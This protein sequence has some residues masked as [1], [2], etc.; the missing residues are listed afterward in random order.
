MIGRDAAPSRAF[1]KLKPVLEE[2]GLEVDLMVGDGQLL[3]QSD[4]EVVLAVE[5]ANLMLLG[6][7]SPAENA[8]PEILAGE[9]AR[10]LEIPYGFYGDV[11]RC[12]ARARKG[13]WFE[14]LAS[15]AEFYFGVTEDDANAAYEVFPNA[16]L[17]GTGNPL[18]EEMA[19]P[20]FTRDEVRA[21]LNIAP[22]EKLILA[23]GG[24]FPGGGDCVSWAIIIE[25]LSILAK[26]REHFQLIMTPHPGDQNRF[27]VYKELASLS[28]VPARVIYRE[29]LRTSEA[30]PGAD[31]IIECGSSIGIEGAYQ[32]IPVV[33][34]GLEIL[35][36]YFEQESGSRRLESVEDGLSEFVPGDSSKLAEAI[37]RLLTPEGYAPM[38]ACQQAMCPKPAKLG[39]ALHKMADAV[40]SLLN[41]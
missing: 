29:V 5:G 2:R 17:I 14:N 1:A 24:R 22:H 10:E 18:R 11:I 6:M 31:I 33:T 3:S 16:Q 38:R 35:L 27:S 26:E 19:F 34:L 8:Q 15:T 21:K 4:Q 13:A 23:P 20:K 36:Q 28:S 7:S 12:W 30:V 40:C 39:T 41:E 25:A 32:E 9:K 37:R